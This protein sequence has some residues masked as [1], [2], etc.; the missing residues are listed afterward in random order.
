MLNGRDSFSRRSSLRTLTALFIAL[1][2]LT[3][4]GT[5]Y[6]AHRGYG[7]VAMAARPG[8]DGPDIDLLERQ[9]KA[10]ERVIQ[11][12]TPAIVYIRT[13]QVIK[14][15]ESPLFMDPMFRQFFGEGL[16]QVPREL[17]QHALGT[18]VIF[19]PNGYVVT[20]NHVIDH[21]S[22]VAIM[23]T[24][25]RM[26][27]AKV[28]GTDPDIDIAVVKI[29]ANNLPTIP[30]GDSSTLH[31]GDTVMAFGNPF[32]LNF[33]VTRGTV[34]AL[35]RSQLNIEPVQDF[36]QTDAAINPGNS[37]GALVDVRGEVVGINT[38]ILSP[39][40]GMG[41]EGGFI[42]IGFA[43]PI[44]M[45]KRTME[46]LIKT[47]KV[48]RGYLGV[49]IGPV[50]PELAQEFKVPDTSGALV[51]D[52]TRGGPADKAGLKPGDVIRKF[53]GRPINDSSDLL[54]MAASVNPGSTVSLDVLRNGKPMDV[55]VKLDQRPAELS[56]T[57]G[58]RRS[59]A[60]GTLRGVVVQNLTSVL[61]KQLG[62]GPEVHG[63]VVR[64]VDPG[65]P[66]AHY[67]EQGDI[68]MSVNHHDVNS[69]AD[70]NKLAAEAKGQTLLRVMHQGEAV[71]VVIPAESSDEH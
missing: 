67:L 63:V 35:G 17:K 57:G 33:T 24:D 30:L 49:T 52:V 15:E 4:L 48:T 45:A 12:T 3:S 51:Q 21:A 5:F 20:N 39:N 29:E 65:S 40:G 68:I 56:Y 58:T 34:S 8:L 27:K 13:E 37:G 9:N 60:E 23:T 38:A 19:Q 53:D 22:T 62:V 28:V 42:G 10:Y 2:G 69:V 47:G 46:S 16:P 1:V 6:L 25:K 66:A 64:D 50:T 11:A 26:F 54:A 43:I 59:P 70:F 55:K 14:A 32:G 18:G 36:I 7:R 44:N 61:R 31:V 71:F 41:G